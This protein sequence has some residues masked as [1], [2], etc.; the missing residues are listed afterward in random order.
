MGPGPFF[1]DG[2]IGQVDA[3]L[4]KQLLIFCGWAFGIVFGVLLY[5]QGREKKRVTVDQPVAATIEGEVV[6]R[7]SAKRFNFELAE[8]RHVEVSRR[9]DDHDEQIK[10]LWG[11]VRGENEDIRDE[12][13][14]GFQSVERALGRIEGKLS[15]DHE[16]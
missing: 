11:T 10:D 16:T 12:M 9:L 15:R 13:R 3:G 7:K 5:L 14:K 6:T 2:D 8:T 4:I 1:A